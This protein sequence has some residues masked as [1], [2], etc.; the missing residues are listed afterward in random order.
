M[1]AGVTLVCCLRPLGSVLSMRGF[2]PVLGAGH[3]LVTLVC[4]SYRHQPLHYAV[5]A[6]SSRL[7]RH[8][9]RDIQEGTCAPTQVYS[10]PSIALH[11]QCNQSSPRT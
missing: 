3:R 1:V 6:F 5:P 9:S 8:K 4:L 11:E 2:V 10:L 7:N